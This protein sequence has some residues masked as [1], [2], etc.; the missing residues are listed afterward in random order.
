M[1]LSRVR[2]VRASLLL[3]AAALW[4][5]LA[6]GQA[7]APVR[8]ATNVER[9]YFPP[10]E[11]LLRKAYASLNLEVEYL[12]L[13]LPRAQLEL[14][15]GRIDAVA[16]RTET[17]F[18]QTPAL[19]RIDVP[20]LQLHLFAYGKPPCPRSITLE[21]L[22]RLRVSLQRGMAAAESVVPE[23]ARVPTNTP[24]DAFLSVST[25]AADYAV[26]LSTPWMVE[27]PVET[28]Q[29]AL[30]VVPTPLLRT[31]L[32]HGVHE[33][34][35]AWVPALEQALRGMRDRGEIQQ[36]W[37]DYEREIATP[38]ARLQAQPGR[39]LVL[40]P[41]PAATPASAPARPRQ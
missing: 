26:M 1:S 35:A 38:N 33:S 11:V 25:G 34:H 27:M 18:E 29:G 22:S 37:T 3:G 40:N 8:I 30:C 24:A 2:A 21:E 20:L 31:T 13:P 9:S 41:A 10:A 16:M 32:Y 19:R 6:S 12:P 15:G 28:R 39:S 14:R 36:A 17:F 7:T 5:G 4:A 23:A